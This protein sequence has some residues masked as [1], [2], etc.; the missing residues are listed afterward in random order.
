MP[1]PM[2]SVTRQ[3]QDFILDLLTPLDPAARRMFGGVGLFH[4]GVMFGLLVRDTFYLRVDD[5]TRAQF[6]RAGS[7]PFSYDRGGRMVS[8]AAYYAVPEGLMD[9]PEELLQWARDAIGA[10]RNAK[11]R[12]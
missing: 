5:T 1:V 8:I 10:A 11:G 2:P 12:R 3:F 7:L 9:Q 6:E 4:S